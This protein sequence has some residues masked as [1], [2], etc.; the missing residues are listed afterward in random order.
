MG[1]Y[2]VAEIARP[3]TIDPQHQL[4]QLELPSQILWQKPVVVNDARGRRYPFHLELIDS[5]KVFVEILKSKF[6]DLGLGKVE[7]GK[8]LLQDHHSGRIL[9]LSKPWGA[10]IRPGQMLDMSMIFRKRDLLSTDCPICRSEND[11]SPETQTKC[12]T[13]GLM[14][15]RI[16]EIQGIRVQKEDFQTPSRSAAYRTSNRGQ[17]PPI[18]SPRPRPL[19]PQDGEDDIS[20]YTRVQIIDTRFRVQKV[21]ESNMVAVLAT[22]RL[23]DLQNT[24]RLAAYL[25]SVCGL[26][27]D[28]CLAALK[29]CDAEIEATANEILNQNRGPQSPPNNAGAPQN[30]ADAMI[31][32]PDFNEPYP[33][34]PFSPNFTH[35]FL[36]QS[37]NMSQFGSS[38]MTAQML[39]KGPPMSTTGIPSLTGSELDQLHN[40]LHNQLTASTKDQEIEQLFSMTPAQ[41]NSLTSMDFSR[42]RYSIESDDFSDPLSPG[43]QPSHRRNLAETL[44]AMREQSKGEPAAEAYARSGIRLH[45]KS[46]SNSSA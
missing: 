35:A 2:P 6:K 31:F 25:A 46:S 29:E 33:F 23:Q 22:L 44:A 13:C 16:E 14:Y 17:S 42:P 11:G 20:N 26:A 3:R 30:Q 39:Q 28:D 8:W 24:G 9:D 19:K 27:E 21:G 34:S 10:V 43:S 37:N 5:A 40:Q 36:Q 4:V 45:Q 41:Y 18:P 32:N 12:S 7:R 1:T 38:S 15:Q